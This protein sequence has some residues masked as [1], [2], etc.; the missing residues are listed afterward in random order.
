MKIYLLLKEKIPLSESNYL[1]QADIARSEMENLYISENFDD[2][3]QFD[4]VYGEL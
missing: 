1:D 3:K 2:G 4:K